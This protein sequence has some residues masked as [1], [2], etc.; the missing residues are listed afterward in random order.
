MRAIE[1]KKVSFSYDG[2]NDR[3]LS[4]ADFFVDYGEV[5]LLSGLSG[6]GKST[7]ISIASGIIPNIVKGKIM[8]EVLIDGNSI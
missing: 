4:D 7:L 2:F 6:E 1:F 8:G 5:A 3:V